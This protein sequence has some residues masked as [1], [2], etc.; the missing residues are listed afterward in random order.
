M[1]SRAESGGAPI[2]AKSGERSEGLWWPMAVVRF[3]T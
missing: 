2:G 1:P 3:H